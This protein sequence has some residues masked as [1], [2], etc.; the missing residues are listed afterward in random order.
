MSVADVNAI[1]RTYLTTASAATNPL[2]AL[3]GDQIY[4]PRLP[5]NVKL[6][7]GAGLSTPAISFFARG[8][9]STPYIP[10][11]VTPSIQFD[12]WATDT[13]IITPP[14]PGFQKARQV[15]RALYDALQGI[16]NV[17]VGS[18]QIKSALEEV[19]GVDMVDVEIPEYYRV[20]T[21]FSMMIRAE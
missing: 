4:C 6:L 17:T 13:I 12:C 3:I 10:G 14:D 16:Q 21:F 19:Q 18:Y 5:E 1:I 11:M 15:Y 2:I 20:L 9:T 8:G 7:D